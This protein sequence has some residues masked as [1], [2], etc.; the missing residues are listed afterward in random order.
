MSREKL[1]PIEDQKII[2]R[3]KEY[4]EVNSKGNDVVR[5]VGWSDKHGCY[6]ASLYDQRTAYHHK[7]WIWEARPSQKHYAIAG[8]CADW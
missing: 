5:R 8:M 7:I 3:I 1:E 4:V 6:I 2:E